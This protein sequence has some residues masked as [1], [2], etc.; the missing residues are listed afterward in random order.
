M[1]VRLLWAALAVLGLV[2]SACGDGGPGRLDLTTPGAHTGA[3]SVSTLAPRA[4]A[5][6]K[7]KA[8][9]VSRREKRVIRGWADELRHGHVAAAARYF[10]VPSL[11]NPDLTP[12]LIVLR[13]RKAVKTFNRGLPCGAR[14]LRT[15]RSADGFV[16][17]VFRLTERPGVGNCGDGKG[18]L[19]AVAFKVRA[20]H[21]MQWMR[22]PDPAEPKAKPKAAPTATPIPR[23]D[24]GHVA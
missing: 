5:T 10:T 4:T 23:A 9:P 3:G 13:S 20:G 17:G 12:G 11:V 21:I 1:T 8:R 24:R 2:A 22:Q 18:H 15:E 19:A 14:L 7:A 6:P 16:V